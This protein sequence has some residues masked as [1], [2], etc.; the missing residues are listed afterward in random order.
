MT[1]EGRKIQHENK[2]AIDALSEIDEEIIL[3]ELLENFVSEE[4][5]ILS[6]HI[7][8]NKL[9]DTKMTGEDEEET[10]TPSASPSISQED[11]MYRLD[12][13]QQVTF[14]F[15]MLE[16]ETFSLYKDLHLQGKLYSFNRQDISFVDLG[17]SLYN[18]EKEEKFYFIKM[19]HKNELLGRRDVYLMA[20]SAKQIQ[21]WDYSLCL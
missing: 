19:V 20:I 11:E 9:F 21:K 17:L 8:K 12:S 13:H 10:N 6:Y 16:N 5:R 2:I 14:C 7:V 18:E 1:I 15:G 4:F 3:D